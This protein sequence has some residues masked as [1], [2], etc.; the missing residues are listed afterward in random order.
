MI[1]K[2]FTVLPGTTKV[3]DAEKGIVEA[4]VNSTGVVDA[5]RDN[6]EPGCWGDV[7]KAAADGKAAHPST[8]WGHD[9]NITTGKVLNSQEYPPGDPAIPAEIADLGAGS[10]K[11]IVQ[12]NLETQRGREA[13][14][15][16]KFGAIRQW[17]VGF[18]PDPDSIRYDAKG[19][20]HIGRVLEWLEVSNVLM[21]ASPGTMTASVKGLLPDERKARTGDRLARAR[22][23]LEAFKAGHRT[24]AKYEMDDGKYP[25]DNCADVEDAWGL[26]NRSTTHSSAQVARHVRHA[27]GE[28]GCDG[29]WNDGS[30]D[31]NGEET[32]KGADKAMCCDACKGVDCPGCCD[33]CRGGS[34]A[35]KAGGGMPGDPPGVPYMTGDES[36]HNG[37][38]MQVLDGI[39][40]LIAQEIAEG[41]YEEYGDIIRLCCLAQDAISWAAGEANEYGDLDMYS[42][43]DLMAAG[44]DALRSK[45]ETPAEEPA[46]KAAP[47]MPAFL[48]AVILELSEADPTS[49]HHPNPAEDGG[50]GLDDWERRYTDR[51][52]GHALGLHMWL[53]RDLRGE[54]DPQRSPE[55]EQDEVSGPPDE[56]TERFTSPWRQQ[57]P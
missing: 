15:D 52:A 24:K 4:W 20:R 38:L 50:D 10:I 13:F 3:L 34:A 57:Q 31:E 22:A 39:N 8:V 45:T 11:A 44:R 35:A 14:S 7:L 33:A 6:M 51:F 29:P 42:I 53:Q 30:H 5:Q 36:V 9:W 40:T 48:K 37:P 32:G 16:V 27:A 47:V 46:E 54:P 1:R 41:G 19:I 23:M 49:S 28:L 56:W 2:S 12:Y 26:R 21:G 43:W 17:S 25:I 18:F 55:G